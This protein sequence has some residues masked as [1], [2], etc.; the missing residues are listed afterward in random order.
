MYKIV[1]HF[2]VIAFTLIFAKSPLAELSP[3]KN[4][5][6][7]YDI[8]IGDMLAGSVDIYVNADL[9]RYIIEGRARSY[10]IFEFLSEYSAI[11]KVIGHLNSKGLHPESYKVLGSW[12]GK[13]RMVEI[14]YELLGRMSYKTV[15]VAAEDDRDPVPTHFLLGTT[16]PMTAIFGAFYSNAGTMVCDNVLKIFDGRRRYNVHLSEIARI[17]TKGPIYTGPAR[18]CRARQTILEGA[19]KRIWLSQFVR[20]KWTDIWI[21][22]VRADLPFLPVRIAADLGIADLVGHLV[23]IGKRNYPTDQTFA[24]NSPSEVNWPDETNLE[25]EQ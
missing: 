20:P 11:Y 1:V 18:V 24:P 3:V 5:Q 16:D 7:A 17:E 19:S 23:A 10:G 9:K 25:M 6:L 13:Q 21:A 4:L 15:P 22:R 8:F 2:C 12:A 14:S